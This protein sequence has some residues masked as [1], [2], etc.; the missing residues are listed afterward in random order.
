MR[1]LF[2]I[3]SL[4]LCLS[5]N[6]SDKLHVKALQDYS[7]QNPSETFKVEAIEDGAM[8]EIPILKGDIINCTLQKTK[9]AKRAK[10]DAKIYF[11]I[12]S[13]EDKKGIHK[14]SQNLTAKYAKTVINKEEVKKKVTPKKAV[15]TTAKVVGGAFVEGA[16]YIVS[17]ADGII[18]NN[19]NNRL[20]SGVKQVY[21]DSFLS[22]IEEGDEV[23]IKTD[24]TFYF[25]IKPT[26]EKDIENN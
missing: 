1:K 7:S 11:N 21:D 9:D 15:K 24:D 16:S 2:L 22:Y 26:K 5:A 8:G 13:Y 4:S 10:I 20:K 18:T 25:I 14:L 3:L 6:A 12:E 23:E 19:E 17:F